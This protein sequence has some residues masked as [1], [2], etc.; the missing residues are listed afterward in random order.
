MSGESINVF[1]R[2]SVFRNLGQS[3][4]SLSSLSSLYLKEPTVSRY[5]FPHLGPTLFR[6]ER[7]SVKMLC[8]ERMPP[9][10]AN[11]SPL[12]VHIFAL[13]A[14]KPNW[15]PLWHV[16]L[17]PIWRIFIWP[18]LKY[19]LPCKRRPLNLFHNWPA[20]L[21]WLLSQVMLKYFLYLS[22]LS[23]LYQPNIRLISKSSSRRFVLF[24][25]SLK[26][27]LVEFTIVVHLLHLLQMHPPF[28]KSN[29][30]L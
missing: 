11:L 25:I 21:I 10:S 3:I 27:S 24:L 15:M 12:F 29:I 16:I 28:P 22:P 30:S 9:S 1:T 17:R 14:A 6:L 7:F 13:I 26:C 19:F 5:L 20:W 4:N 8:L 23:L 18:T 2:E